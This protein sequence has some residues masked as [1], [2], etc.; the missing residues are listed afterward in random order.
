MNPPRRRS[1]V[2]A[3]ALLATAGCAPAPSAAPTPLSSAGSATA[4]P[5]P[6]PSDLPFA[7]VTWPAEG[8]AC[9]SDGT[10][11]RIA[12]IEA[13]D[14]RTVVFRLC[15][16]DGAFLAR[17]AVPALG[18][19][20]AADLE[21]VAA[22]PAALR[23]V[24]G[25]GSYRVVR[26]GASNVELGRVGSAAADAAAPTV[27]LRWAADAATRTADLIAGSV[28]G[29]D[30]PT[31]DGLTAAATT[32]SLTVVP[33]PLL[34]TAV[35]GFGRGSAFADARVRRAVASGIDNAGLADT[36]F[37]AGST[38]ADHLAPCE[39]PSGC[40][41]SA[42]RGFNAPASAAA[43]QSLK[44]NLDASYT[45]TVPDAPIPGLPD[46]AGAAAAV[47]D[48][49]AANLG[50][51]A[52][53]TVLPADQFRAAV[54]GGTIQGLY[55]DGVAAPFADPSAFY[56]PLLLD[57]PASLAA[58]LAGSALADLRAADASPDPAARDAGYASVADLVRDSVPVAPLVHPGSA[59]VYRTD[60]E[61]AAA[62]PLGDDPLGAMTAGD[63][64]QVVFEQASAPGGG[65][66]GAQDTADAYR[67]C[68]LVTDGLYGYAAG[69]QDPAPSLATA[70]TPSPDATVWTCRLRTLRTSDG[71]VLDAADVVATFRAMAD[72]ADPVHR[73]LGDAAFTTWSEVLGAASGPHAVASPS[74]AS[75][76]TVAPSALPSGS[77]APA[78][79]GGASAPP[80]ASGPTSPSAS[81]P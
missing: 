15:A 27:I 77:A 7:P 29:I 68:A 32:P 38:A 3:V 51:T 78:G 21:R 47:R 50:L 66:C 54:D 59:T 36:A 48:Q 31:A 55:L 25:H 37:P 4:A 26:W 33:R 58:R 62:A 41:G 10:G 23:N 72:P 44:F 17:L 80:G 73:A 45:L 79:S 75:S 65:W 69:T 13:P 12:R 6:E 14:A 30:V 34:A 42:F 39:V 28:D 20:D 61:G 53:V 81:T 52:E 19:V 71:L 1:A 63:R 67:L 24:A 57:H 64:G 76:A 5:T 2:L 9:S 43:L 11:G 60:V 35:L 40:A 70:C 22:D 46:P 49:F 16:P 8:T 18:I 74:P 56:D